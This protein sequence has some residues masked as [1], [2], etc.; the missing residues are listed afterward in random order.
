MPPWLLE[1]KVV[2]LEVGVELVT[3]RGERPGAIKHARALRLVFC[4]EGARQFLQLLLPSAM[5]G[6][7]DD[8]LEPCHGHAGDY[9]FI[10]A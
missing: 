2:S 7:D 3:A 4:V 9:R 8:V 1:R 10:R 6:Q 5:L